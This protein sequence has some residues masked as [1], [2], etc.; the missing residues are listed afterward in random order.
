LFRGVLFL[1]ASVV[2]KKAFK[3]TTCIYQL[4]SLYC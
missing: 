1:A 3:S 2:A 4:N